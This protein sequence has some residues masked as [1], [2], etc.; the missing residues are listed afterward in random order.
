MDRCSAAD[1]PIAARAIGALTRAQGI[2]DLY[3][4]Y[5]T[6]QKGGIEFNL[7]HIPSAF[8]ASHSAEFDT[9]YMRRLYANGREMA[10]AGFPWEKS[11]PGLQALPEVTTPTGK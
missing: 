5:A 11:P 9:S 3:R 1:S 10:L 6:T 2:G 8:N 7:A 4:I